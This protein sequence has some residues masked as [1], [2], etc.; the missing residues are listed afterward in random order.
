MCGNFQLT[1]RFVHPAA[2]RPWRSFQPLALAQLDRRITRNRSSSIVSSAWNALTPTTISSPVLT[3]PLE[4]IGGLLDFVRIN[5]LDR[6]QRF[7]EL[8][9]FCW[10]YAS[11]CFSSSSV[12]YSTRYDPANGSIESASRTCWR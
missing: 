2:S 11:A 10:M 1:Q 3:R 4:R 6:G 12:R 5:P 8:V 9:G 7:P